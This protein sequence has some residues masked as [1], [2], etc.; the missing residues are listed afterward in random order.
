MR[1]A[2]C[3]RTLTCWGRSPRLGSVLA[4][5]RG[6]DEINE[7]ALTAWMHRN[8]RLIAVAVEDAD[9]LGE[10]EPRVLSQLDPPLNLDKV[11]RNALRARLSE[12]RRK[13]GRKRR[14][15]TP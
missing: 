11:V 5:A 7:A 8:L 13:Y 10:I 12:L 3:A 15:A 6:E 14:S 2:G 4:E 9:T 1:H